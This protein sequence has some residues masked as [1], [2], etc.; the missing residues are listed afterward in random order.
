MT[1][2]SRTH[3]RKRRRV[4]VFHRRI[5]NPVTRRLPAQ[6]LLETTGR[7]SGPAATAARQCSASRN[8]GRL[9]QPRSTGLDNSSPP[10]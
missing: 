7:V 9:N 3:D 5:A 2:D 4:S 8:A 6:I 1:F 10:R